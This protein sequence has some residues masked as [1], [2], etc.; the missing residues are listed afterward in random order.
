MEVVVV[1]ETW[2]E[3]DTIFLVLRDVMA[4]ALQRFFLISRES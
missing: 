3:S 2:V 1:M 4:W